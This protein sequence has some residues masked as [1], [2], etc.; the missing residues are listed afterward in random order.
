M[1]ADVSALALCA[2]LQTSLAIGDRVRSVGLIR[3]LWQLLRQLDLSAI[4]PEQL[5][6]VY[7]WIQPVL[8]GQQSLLE[9][10]GT[11]TPERLADLRELWL[12]LLALIGLGDSPAVAAAAADALVQ[13][14]PGEL[15]GLVA[16]ALCEA[17]GS[18]SSHAAAEAQAINP[19]TI[20]MLVQ[21]VV[22]LLA[23]FRRGS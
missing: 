2:D 5:K 18:E 6:G 16:E 4:D 8:T 15:E 22:T 19:Q 17:P 21:L 7:D 9:F 14:A 13:Y 11:I 10:L 12:D 20:L 23:K 1:A 3:K